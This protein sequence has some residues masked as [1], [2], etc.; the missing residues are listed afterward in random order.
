V[1]IIIRRPW[2][3]QPQ[4]I[5]PIA[6]EFTAGILL[7]VNSANGYINL[8]DGLAGTIVGNVSRQAGPNGIGSK[9]PSG[10]GDGVYWP[11]KSITGAAPFT[12]LISLTAY[13]G[14]GA[15]GG[16]LQVAGTSANS[17][18]PQIFIQ[19]NN[20]VVGIFDPSTFYAVQEAG[21]FPGTRTFVVSYDGATK[22]LY[23]AGKVVSQTATATLGANVATH[24]WLNNGYQGSRNSTQYVCA[25]WDRDLSEGKKKALTLNPWQLFTPQLR[26]IPSPSAGA[27]LPTLSSATYVPG[28]ITSTG[29]RP[30]VTA[31]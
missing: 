25:Y 21:V 11:V 4:V 15:L 6:A 12:L 3:R 20:D 2:T 28:S 24:L 23:R 30:R 17:G 5:K 18:S 31:S 10:G 29:F 22:K 16:L 13:E 7:A 1:T 8:A 26:F 9:T 14:A 27:T 19:Q